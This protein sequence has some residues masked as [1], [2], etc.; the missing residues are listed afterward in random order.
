MEEDTVVEEES[1]AHT[2]VDLDKFQKEMREFLQRGLLEDKWILK[3]NFLCE[4][5]DGKFQNLPTV[6]LEILEELYMNSFAILKI[7][8]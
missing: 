5:L 8:F 7:L 4:T 6:V 3:I 2:V 1:K